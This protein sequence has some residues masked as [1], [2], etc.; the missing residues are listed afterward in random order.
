MEN[1]SLSWLAP[2]CDSGCR[3]FESHRS[4]Q[5]INVLRVVINVIDKVPVRWW[6]TEN[7]TECTGLSPENPFK[8]GQIGLKKRPWRVGFRV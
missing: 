2:N 7:Q 4:P 1:Q 5:F 3:G 8:E 6:C